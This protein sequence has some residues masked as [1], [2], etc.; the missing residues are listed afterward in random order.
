MTKTEELYD[1]INQALTF[2]LANLHTIVVCKVTE[3]GEKTI[4]CRP[5]INRVMSGE[6]R[7]FENDF[8]EV[9]PIFLNGGSSHESWPISVDDYCLLFISERCFDAWYYGDDFVDPIEMRMHDYS[10]GFALVGIQNNAGAISIPDLITRIGDMYAQGDW[11]HDGN[12]T[13][14]G[15]ETVVGDREQTGDHTTVGSIEATVKVFA[16][17][18]QGVLQGVGGGNATSDVEFTATALHAQNG[19]SGT[20]ATGDSRTVTVVDGII[21]EVS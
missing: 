14:T 21:T 4:S 5:V 20:F 17:I 15:N 9:P 12:L 16:P 13:R 7:P 19:W 11:G 2:A 18:V 8:V 6:S 3:V 1:V 10:D